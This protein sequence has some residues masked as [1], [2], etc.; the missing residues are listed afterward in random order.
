MVRASYC[1]TSSPQEMETGNSQCAIPNGS[2]LST[3][4]GRRLSPI[5]CITATP[6]QQVHGLLEAVA[7]RLASSATIHRRCSFRTAPLLYFATVLE[8]VLQSP[9]LR[10]TG[11][12]TPHSSR[13]Q[14]VDQHHT[15]CGKTLSLILIRTDT[16]MSC[17]TSTRRTR[18]TGCNT[19]T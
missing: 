18:V 17:R 13:R 5:R 15:P 14:W 11:G 4:L 10:A 19:Q 16:G 6:D 2:H 7:C 1:T 3:K 9:T 8:S 12:R